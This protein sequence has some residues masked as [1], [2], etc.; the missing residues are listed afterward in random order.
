M[1]GA[2]MEWKRE[3]LRPGTLALQL[4]QRGV[5]VERGPRGRRRRGSRGASTRAST[6]ALAGA[7]PLSPPVAGLGVQQRDPPS[8]TVKARSDSL[9]LLPADHLHHPHARSLRQL[10]DPGGGKLLGGGHLCPVMRDGVH[11]GDVGLL[12]LPFLLALEL[13]EDLLEVLDPL[14]RTQ[15]PSA[16]VAPPLPPVEHLPHGLQLLVGVA[17]LLGQLRLLRPGRQLLLQ[18]LLQLP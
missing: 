1:L 18:R 10:G 7:Y 6:G 2:R 17:C 14:F 15:R 13:E 8:G 3:A 11:A 16:D 4:R 5:S 12:A 9:V